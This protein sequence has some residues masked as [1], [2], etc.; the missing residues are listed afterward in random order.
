M[1]AL[2]LGIASPTDIFNVYYAERC[3]WHIIFKVN[4]DQSGHGSLLLKNT[5]GEKLRNLL[6]KFFAYRDA[7][8]EK[9]NNNPDLTIGDVTTINVTMINGGVLSNVVPPDFTI[10]TD[11]RL[12]VDV[13]HQEFENMF[14]RWCVDSGENIEYEWDLKDPFIPPTSIDDSNIFWHAFK[15]AVNEL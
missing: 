14:K 8:V 10:M 13:D 5:A 7:Q 6:D 12:A 2:I 1:Y 11:F 3:I 4:G 15:T 9:L